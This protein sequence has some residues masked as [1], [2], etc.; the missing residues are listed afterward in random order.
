MVSVHA[1]SYIPPLTFEPFALSET[2]KALT[3]SISIPSVPSQVPSAYSPTRIRGPRRRRKFSHPISQQAPARPSDG[4]LLVA[5]Q[6][7]VLRKSTTIHNTRDPLLSNLSSAASNGV[8]TRSTSHIASKSDAPGHLDHNAEDFSLLH[9]SG[10]STG[11]HCSAEGL[12][13][14][15]SSRS[16][17]NAT[18]TNAHTAVA[19]EV[20]NP[21]TL[22]L[23]DPRIVMGSSPHISSYAKTTI[24]QDDP[25]AASA[26]PTTEHG[27][28]DDDVRAHRTSTASSRPSTGVRENT[29]DQLESLAESLRTTHPM[30][31]PDSIRPRVHGPRHGPRPRTPQSGSSTPRS[32]PTT[33]RVQTAFNTQRRP[34]D[35]ISRT[36]YSAAPGL[37]AV[38]DNTP[39][40][41]AVSQDGVSVGES[42]SW[43]TAAK[44]KWKTAWVEVDQDEE[45]E[46]VCSET[47]VVTIGPY[48]SCRVPLWTLLMTHY[49]RA[50]LHQT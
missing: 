14:H 38:E 36:I 6:R 30:L 45:Q 2:H 43:S 41:A 32:G 15:V 12:Q 47:I 28:D 31:L 3:A 35:D 17:G 4:E 42:A 9:R 21:S 5:A 25:I 44:G 8:L 50:A 1:P 46:M 7:P 49:C 26:A 19:E 39:S 29:I 34:S 11:E 37:G 27:S 48:L 18:G 22:K 16:P 24:L 20:E 40:R 23:D 13:K 33:P 10:Q